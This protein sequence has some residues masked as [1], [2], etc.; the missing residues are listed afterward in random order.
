[1]DS[2]YKSALKDS[3]SGPGVPSGGKC[4]SND[5]V[6]VG[7]LI[8]AAGRGSRMKGFEGNKTLLPLRAGSFP[9]EGDH[10]ILTHILSNLPPGPR[11]VVVN[12]RAEDVINATKNMNLQYMFQPETNGTGGA[13]IAARAFLEKGGFD[14]LIITMGDVPLVKASSYLALSEALERND[15]VILAFSP[16]EKR[17][18]G[19]LEITDGRV[20]RILEYQYWSR[21]SK[22]DQHALTLANAGIYAARRELIFRYLPALES[23]PHTVIKSYQGVQREIKE[24]FITD[25]VEILNADGLSVGCIEASDELEVMGVDDLS[26]LRTAQTAFSVINSN[27]PRQ[28]AASCR[29]QLN[30]TVPL[31]TR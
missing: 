5:Q 3:L 1:M 15:L 2:S 30:L 27:K 28:D 13:L 4:D 11:A 12:H 16:K 20:N 6:T 9:F 24:Y 26:A 14:K 10:P 31:Q 8:F 22:K 21:L 7:S 25:L 29:S 19:L 23:R 18:Y 17:Q